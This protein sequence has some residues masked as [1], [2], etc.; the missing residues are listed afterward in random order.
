MAIAVAASH[1]AGPGPHDIFEAVLDHLTNGLVRQGVEQARK[2]PAISAQEAA[3]QLGNGSRI[4]AEDT[5][6]FTLWVAAQHLNDYETAVRTCAAVG[7]DRD[8]TA[9]IVGGII[10]ARAPSIPSI[11]RQYREPLPAWFGHDA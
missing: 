8:T 2:L 10:G 5:V 9:A 1:V 11:W 4:T 3:A 6:P 7:G